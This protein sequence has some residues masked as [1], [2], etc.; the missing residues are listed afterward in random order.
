MVQYTSLFVVCLLTETDYHR[1]IPPYYSL[2]MVRSYRTS[3]GK[4][5]TF[6]TSKL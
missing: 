6:K 1:T 2:P 3:H 5:T 4:M